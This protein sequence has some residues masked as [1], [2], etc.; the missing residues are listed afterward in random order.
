[1]GSTR[2]LVGHLEREV[3]SEDAEFYILDNVFRVIYFYWMRR[4]PVE[5]GTTQL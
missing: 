3:N 1:M 4:H 2:H 5:A